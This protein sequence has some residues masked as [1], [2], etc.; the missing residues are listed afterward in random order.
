MT[1]LEDALIVADDAC[2]YPTS[3]LEARLHILTDYPAIQRQLIDEIA[4]RRQE[5]A[6]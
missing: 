2:G 1:A 5:T 3:V 6:A 4:R